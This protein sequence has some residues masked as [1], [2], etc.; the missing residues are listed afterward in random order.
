MFHIK[1]R[2]YRICLFLSGCICRLCVHLRCGTTSVVAPQDSRLPGKHL[3]GSNHCWT[4]V[5]HSPLVPLP[6]C[7]TAHVQHC[8]A[9]KTCHRIIDETYSMKC[10]GQAISDLIKFYFFFLFFFF[11]GRRYCYCVDAAYFLHQQHLS[12]CWD[13]SVWP[14]PQQHIPLHACLYWRHPWLSRYNEAFIAQ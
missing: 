3:L 14:F 5:V 7:E 12:V 9:N 4:A 13:L 6:A 2:E 11:T 8:K 10:K 1:R